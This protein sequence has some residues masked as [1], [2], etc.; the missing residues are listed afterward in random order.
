[1]HRLKDKKNYLWT[2]KKDKIDSRWEKMETM[3]MSCNPG[4]GW[5]D[6]WL[7]YNS[8]TACVAYVIL[9]F[10]PLHPYSISSSSSTHQF[11]IFSFCQYTLCICAIMTMI[12]EM[13]LQHQSISQHKKCEWMKTRK[14]KLINNND[15]IS[16]CFTHFSP[17]NFN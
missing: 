12:Y 13:S 8:S 15:Y 2:Q 14:E 4:D 5:M 10:F 11:S 17:I 1:M 7:R 3:K 16:R 6:A 9:N